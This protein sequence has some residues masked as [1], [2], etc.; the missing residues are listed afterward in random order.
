MSDRKDG[1]DLVSP[2]AEIGNIFVFVGKILF[3]TFLYI[4]NSGQHT[5]TSVLQDCQLLRQ[6]LLRHHKRSGHTEALSSGGSG[7]MA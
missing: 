3:L 7:Q 2:Q 6:L 4:V 1:L 5:H